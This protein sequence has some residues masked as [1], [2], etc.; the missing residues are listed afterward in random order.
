MAIHEDMMR[1]IKDDARRAGER[2]RLLREVR[3]ARKAGRPKLEDQERIGG[4]ATNSVDSTA[5]RKQEVSSDQSSSRQAIAPSDPMARGGPARRE[6]QSRYL[7]R[8]NHRARNEDR[9]NDQRRLGRRREKR[10]A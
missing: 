3:R 10:S 9:E 1:A 7:S 2:D 8:S 4:W 6:G 5:G